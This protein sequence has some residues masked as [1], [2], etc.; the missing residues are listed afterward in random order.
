[1]ANNEKTVI[2][3]DDHETVVMYLSILLRRMGFTVI[4]ARNG[5]EVLQ[6]L[7][8]ILPDL[9][10]T[11]R[12]MPI[13]DGLTVLKMMKGDP[14]LAAIPVIMVTAHFEQHAFDE[15]MASGGVGF[16]TKPIKLLELH[17]VLRECVSYPNHLKR[18]NLRVAYGHKVMLKY[19][20]QQ[21]EYYAVT[22]SEQG[23][24]LRTPNP[25]P[26]GAAVEVELRVQ[27]G[28]FFTF[29]GT[30]IYQKNL[31][32]DINL[33]DP[34]MAVKFHDLQARDAGAL[35]AYIMDM[36]AGDLMEEQAEPVIVIQDDKSPPF[37]KGMEELKQNW[38]SS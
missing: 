6:L 8:T 28:Q 22:L 23:I 32:C 36:L 18:K 20:N 1:M 27:T 15:C 4:P 9:V 7:E 33:L 3:A 13:M 26:V 19:E 35:K 12:K 37:Q 16:L 25:L 21:Q 5:K 30:V 10:I 2:I 17:H 38:R 24:Y 29:Q 14:H 11:D 34:G 31:S